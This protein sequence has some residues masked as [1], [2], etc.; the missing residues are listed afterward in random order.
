MSLIDDVSLIVDW[1]YFNERFNLRR[2]LA[3]NLGSVLLSGLELMVSGLEL[4]VSGLE[5]MVSGL[6][7][8]VSVLFK[9]FDIVLLNSN[10]RSFLL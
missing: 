4:M 8:M 1:L 2:C 10:L 3:F 7:L 6:E 9:E 5:L